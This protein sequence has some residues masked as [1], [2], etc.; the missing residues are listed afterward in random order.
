MLQSLGAEVSGP[1]AALVMVVFIPLFGGVSDRIGRPRTYAIGSALLALSV[2]PAFAL[3]S[4]GNPVLVILGLVLPFG[5]IYPICYGPEAALFAP[6]GNLHLLHGPRIHHRRHTAA[7]SR[8]PAALRTAS[9]S[10]S[11]GHRRWRAWR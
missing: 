9:T 10:R 8:T 7:P 4:T 2:F 11:R 5:I 3:M 1:M 6:G